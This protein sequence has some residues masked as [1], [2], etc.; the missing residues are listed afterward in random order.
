MQRTAPKPIR[1]TLAGRNRVPANTANPK[2]KPPYCVVAHEH[3]VVV[4]DSG[5]DT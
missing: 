1:K 4:L 2:S 5:F 3:Y